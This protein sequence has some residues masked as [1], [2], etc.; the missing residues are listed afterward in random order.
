MRQRSRRSDTLA[1]LKQSGIE[2]VNTGTNTISIGSSVVNK[3]LQGANRTLEATGDILSV[4]I[5]GLEGTANR[6]SSYAKQVKAT[7]NP[8]EVD[9]LKM[10]IATV[11]TSTLIRA[12]RDYDTDNEVSNAIKLYEGI[13]D[14]FKYKVELAKELITKHDTSIEAIKDD[15]ELAILDK[16][17]KLN[18]LKYTLE[19]TIYDL[20]L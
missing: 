14:T 9:A 18:E 8:A 15:K 5:D 13:D 20:D 7:A 11:S 10:F 4:G 12:I 17:D 6:L 2:L 3:S 1:V 16:I 19:D